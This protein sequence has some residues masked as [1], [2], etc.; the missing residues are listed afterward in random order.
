MQVRP[1][2]WGWTKDRGAGRLN[3]IMYCGGTRGMSFGVLWGVD[4]SGYKVDE[5]TAGRLLFPLLR[6]RL[7]CCTLAVPPTSVTSCFCTL[8]AA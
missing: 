2:L 5:R 4:V 6:G 3:R 1:E 7:W 8:V